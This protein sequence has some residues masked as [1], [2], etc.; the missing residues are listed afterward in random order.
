MQSIQITYFRYLYNLQPL[1]T[2]FGFPDSRPVLI[3]LM[4]IL[5]FVTAPYNAVLDFA[6]TAL[7]RRFEFQGSLY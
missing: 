6:M 4:V 5:Q 7:S 2:A 1:Y 3:G